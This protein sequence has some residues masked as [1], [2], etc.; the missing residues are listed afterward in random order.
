MLFRT[1]HRYNYNRHCWH[2]RWWTI[3]NV[4]EIYWKF[5]PPLRL[6]NSHFCLLFITNDEN[7]VLT[8]S[9]KALMYPVINCIHYTPFHLYFQFHT[10]WVR[11]KKR[12]EEKSNLND[13]KIIQRCELSGMKQNAWKMHKMIL[14]CCLLFRYSSSIW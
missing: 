7:H 9:T 14:K 8:L 3:F 1:W 11:K 6:I 5:V 2:N 13:G 12:W 4:F 10:H